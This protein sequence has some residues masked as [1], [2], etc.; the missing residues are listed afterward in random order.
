MTT[1][2]KAQAR[3]VPADQP[4]YDDER[5][6]VAHWL[7][8]NY[9]TAIW[10][11]YGPGHDWLVAADDLLE[12]AHAAHPATPTAPATPAVGAG[13]S[14]GANGAQAG[15]GELGE[16]LRKLASE[17]T[18]EWSQYAAVYALADRADA[19]ERELDSARRA[20]EAERRALLAA[21]LSIAQVRA[22][23]RHGLD[24]LC[25]ECSFQYPCETSLAI[26]GAQ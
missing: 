26:G 14:E 8:R 1:P 18:T 5:Q 25:T 24:H 17:H 22:L 13:S 21:N 3:M 23:H 2:S 6:A 20:Q 10:A 11:H 12:V 9:G 15:A 19:L 16:A 7:D 4:E